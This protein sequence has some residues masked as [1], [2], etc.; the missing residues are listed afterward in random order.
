VSTTKPLKKEC[1][2]LGMFRRCNYGTI[3]DYPLNISILLENIFL[4][5]GKACNVG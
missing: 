4:G 2:V 5:G 3:L 1:P